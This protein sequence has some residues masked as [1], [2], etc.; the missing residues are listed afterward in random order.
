MSGFVATTPA[1]TESAISNTD[2]YPPVSIT[3]FRAAMR[4]DSS[5]TLDRIQH[6]LVAAMIDVNLDLRNWEATQKSAG[7]YDLDSV[8]SAEINGQSVLLSLYE[9]AVFSYAKAELTEQYRD[10]DATLTG[11]QRA[12]ELDE[13]IGQYRRNTLS[14]I[15]QIIGAQRTTI[16]LI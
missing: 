16:E 4:L 15:R 6:A 12:D 10:Y 9:R 13:T 5:I 14:A 1:V 11:S 3:R 2:F 8:P 7:I